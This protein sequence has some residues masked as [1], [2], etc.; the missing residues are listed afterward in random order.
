VPPAVAH[1]PAGAAANGRALL[2]ACAG[3]V[4]DQ[5]LIRCDSAPLEVVVRTPY[6][7]GRLD[8]GDPR[9][10]IGQQSIDVVG[11]F[12]PH[13]PTQLEQGGVLTD[14]ERQPVEPIRNVKQRHA[15]NMRRSLKGRCDAGHDAH[16]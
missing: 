6:V 4:R 13:Q 2:W 9:L 12:V 14:K 10:N 15:Q 7:K 11:G 8:L 1:R 5:V 3:A 16:T